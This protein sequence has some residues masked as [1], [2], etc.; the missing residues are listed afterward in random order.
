M[1][2]KEQWAQGL[3]GAGAWFAG[4]GPQYE[5]AKALES[6]TAADDE[7]Q[8]RIDDL[9]LNKERVAAMT[10]D[11]AQTFSLIKSGRPDLAI[12]LLD[13]RL[14]LIEKMGGDTYHT[15][16]LR[17]KIAAGSPDVEPELT[18]YLTAA[19]A[20]PEAGTMGSPRKTSD[21]GMAVYDRATNSMIPVNTGGMNFNTPA[22]GGG[23]AQKGSTQVVMKDGQPYIAGS[24]FNPQTQQWSVQMVPFDSTGSGGVYEIPDA[25]GLPPSLR[26]E[27]KARESQAGAAGTAAVKRSE[28]YFDRVDKARSTIAGI[29]EAI[30]AI[31]QGANTG[32]VAQYLPS[33]TDASKQLDAAARR[34]GL[35]VVGSVTFGALSEGELKMAMSTAL[36]KDMDPPQLRKWL[37]D[38]KTAQTKLASY[39]ESAAIY[40]GDTDE[41]GKP[42][43]VASWAKM[44]K[45]GRPTDDPLGLR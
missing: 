15:Q 42:H 19:G 12:Q 4:Q 38:K 9:A 40:L 7:R 18:A 34:M 11:F 32:A 44:Q 41:N 3:Q 8:R 25:S 2:T 16:T 27:Q 43:T 23:D 35:D 26:P 13:N 20:M 45:Q 30:T 1:A 36:P 29:D 22:P 17:D 14:P 21:G 37:V 24:V 39:L 6:R 31:D 28:A 10:Q 33:V 5:A